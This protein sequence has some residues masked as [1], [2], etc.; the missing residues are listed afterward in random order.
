MF[1]PVQDQS[2][3][4]AS[5]NI[6]LIL[7][8]NAFASVLINPN[9]SWFQIDKTLEA[10]SRETSKKPVQPRRNIFKDIR[11]SY[12]GMVWWELSI[13]LVGASLRQGDFASKITPPDC[14]DL[15][16]PSSLETACTR[17]HR[18]LRLFRSGTAEMQVPTMDIDLCWHTHQLFPATYRNWCIQILHRVINH[19]D[20][21]APG[22]LNEGLRR[23]SLAWFKE[24]R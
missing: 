4:D 9:P 3:S 20:T 10:I 13:D 5:T 19:D 15:D 23:T 7:A 17:Y 21:I 14:H 2:V 16:T 22:D 24:L 6:S 18:F 12:V 1:E 8:S 11:A